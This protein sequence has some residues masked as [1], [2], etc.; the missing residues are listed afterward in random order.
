MACILGAASKLEIRPVTRFLWAK[1]C[2]R[3]EIYRQLCDVYGQSKMS[4][5]WEMMHFDRESEP[6]GLQSPL[7]S[8]TQFDDELQPLAAATAGTGGAG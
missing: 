8:I 1:E 6:I 5:Y 2:S 7:D 4:S 3:A